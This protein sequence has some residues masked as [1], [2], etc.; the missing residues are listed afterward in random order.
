MA[1][2]LLSLGTIQVHDYNDSSSIWDYSLGEVNV[3]TLITSIG[4][5]DRGIIWMVLLAN[6]PQL[7]VSIAY[8]MYNALLSCMLLA[9]EYDDY[10]LQRKPLRVSWPKGSQ[11][12]TY[13]LS[14]PYR[15]SI[16]LQGA[17]TVLH[18]LVSQSLYFVEIIPYDIHG[19]P[20]DEAKIITCGYSPQATIFAMILGGVLIAGSIIL[21]MRRF[22]SSMPLALYCSA[23]ISAACHPCTEGDHSMK[24]VQ[25]GEVVSDS[26][27]SSSSSSRPSVS[28]DT[29]DT[30]PQSRTTS[31]GTLQYRGRA[32]LRDDTGLDTSGHRY[33]HCSFTSAAVVEPDASRQYI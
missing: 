23:A 4:L 5:P 14:L 6:T 12:S 13:Y 28:S 29:G 30:M 33:F 8:F 10:A 26:Y 9:A 27:S 25:W 15:Y 20:V 1:G 18:W 21:G 24:P 16:P 3:A 2:Y 22:K 19:V 7:L 32:A 31:T 17:S 11:R